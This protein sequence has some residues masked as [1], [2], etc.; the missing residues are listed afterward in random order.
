MHVT[1]DV[2]KAFA[3]YSHATG[4]DVFLGTQAWPVLAGAADWLTS[5]G[6][7][8]DRGW[9]IRNAMGIAERKRPADNPAF[10]NMAATVVLREAIACAERCGYRAPER[11]S[12]MAAGLVIPMNDAGVILDHD[13]YTRREEKA[14][15]PAALAGLFPLG[16]PV[17]KEVE[18]ATLRFYLDMADDYAGSPM[19]SALL[20]AWAAR[21]PDRTLSA[22]LFEEGFGKF[23]SGRFNV[24]HEYRADRF[25]EEPISGPFLANIGGFLIA[26][27]YGLTGI[28][29][30]PGDPESW[31]VR[32]VAMPELWDAVEVDRVWIRGEEAALRAKHGDEKATIDGRA[33]RGKARRTFD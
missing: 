33:H 14:G 20:G 21:L 23:A 12:S 19:L 17:G 25:P 15:T 11:W 28:Q 5:R 24:V 1:A 18:Q 8:T 31:C 30:G 22:R 9:E 16:Y 6:L 26:C 7:E 27:L 13:G 3:D 29:L 10:V 32:P 2:A 4:D